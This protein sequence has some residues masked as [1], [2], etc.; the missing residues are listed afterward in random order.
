MNN[1]RKRK[2]KCVLE[3]LEPYNA[4]SFKIHVSLPGQQPKLKRLGSC[5][6]ITASSMMQIQHFISKTIREAI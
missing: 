3:Y 6:G 5:K 2:K 4:G 1:K